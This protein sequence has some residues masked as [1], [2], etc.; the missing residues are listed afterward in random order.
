ML[1][2]RKDQADWWQKSIPR[3][4]SVD[5]VNTEARGRMRSICWGKDITA[6]SPPPEV[7]MSD[8]YGECKCF[9]HLCS[10][11]PRADI[12]H[13]HTNHC[14]NAESRSLLFDIPIAVN[15]PYSV[16]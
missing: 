3:S 6:E 8:S 2:L 10:I 9:Q 12:E 15:P 7:A 11:S 4:V 16:R 5:A 13:E 1:A 14:L